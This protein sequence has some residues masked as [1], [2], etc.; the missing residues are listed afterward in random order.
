MRN[1]TARVQLFPLA[2]QDAL[3]AERFIATKV[4]PDDPVAATAFSIVASQRA[5]VAARVMIEQSDLLIAIWDGASPGSIAPA[6]RLHRPSALPRWISTRPSSSRMIA[7]TDGTC[8]RW[9]P[10]LARRSLR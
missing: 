10:T 9:F 7:A 3:V 2:E 8:R 5:A 1:L 6:G 4:A